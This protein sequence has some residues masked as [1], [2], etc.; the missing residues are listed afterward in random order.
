M[1]TASLSRSAGSVLVCVLL[2]AAAGVA[3]GQSPAPPRE[4]QPASPAAPP[5][6]QQPQFQDRLDRI[7]EAKASIIARTHGVEKFRKNPAIQTDFSIQ[8]ADREPLEGVMALEINSHRARIDLSNGIWIGFDGSDTW[9]TNTNPEAQK[10]L[11]V[12]EGR[13][14]LFTWTQLFTLPFTMRE[15][16]VQPTGFKTLNV[17]GSDY[18]SFILLSERQ[19]KPAAQ[20]W[21]LILADQRTHLLHGV[22]FEMSQVAGESAVAKTI[23]VIYSDYRTIGGTEVATKWTFWKWD[24]GIQGEPIGTAT[25]TNTRYLL[26]PSWTFDRGGMPETPPPAQAPSEPADE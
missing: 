25:F 21:R 19:I 8:F 18:D 7:A 10:P 23:C 9:V 15:R 24:N 20:D 26:L 11:S 3:A 2:H 1:L 17:N 4:N 22:A 14:H 6:P 12:E 5:Q 13:F 16:G